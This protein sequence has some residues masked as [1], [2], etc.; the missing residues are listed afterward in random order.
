MYLSNAVFQAEAEG[1]S[2]HPK[3]AAEHM[4]AVTAMCKGSASLELRRAGW[5]M[6]SGVCMPDELPSG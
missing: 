2:L 4:A 5:L 1:A 3:K 6:N